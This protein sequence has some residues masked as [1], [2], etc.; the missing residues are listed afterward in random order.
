MKRPH[1]DSA[2]L[3]IGGADGDEIGQRNA[4]GAAA[5]CAVDGP[6]ERRV[7][8]A[9]PSYAS[10][11]AVELFKLRVRLQQTEQMWGAAEKQVEQTW[12]EAA[13]ELQ[14]MRESRDAEVVQRDALEKQNVTLINELGEAAGS[15]RLQALQ[16]ASATKGEADGAALTAHLKSQLQ[17]V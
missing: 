2:A 5:C 14:R 6:S 16:L 11:S 10:Q 17:V 1:V 15:N 8:C 3:V 9:S 4:E 13:R 7:D 12:M